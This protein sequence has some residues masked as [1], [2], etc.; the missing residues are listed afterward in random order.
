MYIY[1]PILCI[2]PVGNKEHQRIDDVF[3]QTEYSTCKDES[4]KALTLEL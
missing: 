2:M 3:L 1:Y 4:V